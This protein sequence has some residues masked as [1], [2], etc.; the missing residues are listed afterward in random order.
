M[1][2]YKEPLYNI[3]GQPVCEICHVGYDK[4]LKHVNSRHS[5]SANEYKERFGYHPRKGI[6]SQ[7]LHAQMRSNALKN[8]N[9]VIMGNLIIGGNNNRFKEGN[10]MSDLEKLSELNRNRMKQKWNNIRNEKQQS[11][12]DVLSDLIKKLSVLPKT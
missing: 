4:L 8:Y 2:A 6:V 1:K 7:K 9:K 12:D 11:K 3:K 10:Q 5:I